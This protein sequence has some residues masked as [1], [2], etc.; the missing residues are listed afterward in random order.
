LKRGGKKGEGLIIAP[1][2]R[3]RETVPKEGRKINLKKKKRGR[4][5]IRTYEKWTSEAFRA[6]L[7]GRGDRQIPSLHRRRKKTR[8]K[9]GKKG[10]KDSG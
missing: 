1:V 2:S 5:A 6:E 3:K 8:K 10:E 4:G 7:R 9:G